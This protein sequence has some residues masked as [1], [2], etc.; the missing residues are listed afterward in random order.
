[1]FSLYGFG[2]PCFQTS[3]KSFSPLY[4]IPFQQRMF[5]KVAFRGDYNEKN[6][7]KGYRKYC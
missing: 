2:F 5:S 7:N 1:M 6:I 4:F 3:P